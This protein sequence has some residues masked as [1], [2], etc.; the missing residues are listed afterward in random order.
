[1]DRYIHAY[2]HIP[3]DRYI[4]AVYGSASRYCCTDGQ[5]YNKIDK[6][7]QTEM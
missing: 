7:R 4:D 6:D 3:R 2:V 5:K 1:M